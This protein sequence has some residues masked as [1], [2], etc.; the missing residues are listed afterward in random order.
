MTIREYIQQ[1]ANLVRWA[2]VLWMIAMFTWQVFNPIRAHYLGQLKFVATIA[3]VIAF[4]AVIG[5]R[6]RCPRCETRFHRETWFAQRSKF[7]RTTYDHCTHCGGSID[8]PM[9]SPANRR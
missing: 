2:V 3:P 6:T 9:D 7:W 5:W 8:E 4:A 1:R